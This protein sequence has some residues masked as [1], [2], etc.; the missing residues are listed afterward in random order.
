LYRSYQTKRLD[1]KAQPL[2]CY[3]YGRK[4]VIQDKL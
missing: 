4:D 1:P 3:I 2:S